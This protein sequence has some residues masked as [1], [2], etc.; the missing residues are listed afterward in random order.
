MQYAISA[1]IGNDQEMYH[2]SADA[3]GLSLA[4]RAQGFTARVQ[5]GD[6]LVSSGADHWQMSLEGFGYGGTVQSVG[7]AQCS[8]SRVL[9]TWMCDVG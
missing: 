8:A 6:L 5:S 9:G 3:A 2:A 7:A 4:N 1:A